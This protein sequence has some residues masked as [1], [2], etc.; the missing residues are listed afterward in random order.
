MRTAMLDLFD[1]AHLPPPL[2]HVA[3][4]FHDLANEIEDRFAE[5]ERDYFAGPTLT[6][7]RDRSFSIAVDQ[8]NAAL[9]AILLAKDA[10]VRMAVAGAKLK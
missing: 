8:K 10:A 1:F 6:E 3:R 7:A 9:N 2:Q 5:Y 4:S